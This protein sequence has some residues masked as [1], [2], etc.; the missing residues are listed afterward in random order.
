MNWYKIASLEFPLWLGR[1]IPKATN[2]YSKELPFGR[3]IGVVPRPGSI[4]KEMEELVNKYDIPLEDV[5]M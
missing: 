3:T 5:S 4:I 2:N 1:E